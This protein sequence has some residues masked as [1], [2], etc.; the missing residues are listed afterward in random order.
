MK[1]IYWVNM[2][3]NKY[4]IIGSINTVIAYFLGIIL[5]EL[6]VKIVSFEFLS[7]LTSFITIGISFTNYKLFL[8]KQRKSIFV[9][10]VKFYS[11]YSIVA[12][13]NMMIYSYLLKENL[14][15]WITQ[16]VVI[17]LS[18]IITY[19]SNNFIV[20]KVKK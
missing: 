2:K 20:F 11:S 15:I 10:L 12:I 5:Y 8:Y 17:V 6:L 1:K 4:F 3:I 14:N 9:E 16:F 7:L 13:I 19:L 18:F